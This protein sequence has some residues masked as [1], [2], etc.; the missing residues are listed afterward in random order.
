MSR[1]KFEGQEVFF[2]KTVKRSCS[3]SIQALQL[4]LL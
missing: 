3:A 1:D 2:T 4:E